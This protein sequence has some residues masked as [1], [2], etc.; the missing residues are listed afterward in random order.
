MTIPFYQQNAEDFFNATV[1][2]DMASLYAPFLERVG[3]QGKILDAGCGSGRDSKAFKALGYDVEA[4]DA[5][6]EMVALAS[7][8]AGIAA[9]QFTFAELDERERYDGIWCCASLLHVAVAELP[10]AMQRLAAALKH[11]GAWYVSF[12]YGSGEREK[13]GRHFT[14]LNEK[15][16]EALVSQLP[17]IEVVAMW[18]TQDKRPERSETWLNA[19]MRKR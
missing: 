9:R 1:G 8:Y 15:A 18:Q 7:E 16:L 12:K 10:D 17:D 13:D 11:R 19:L 14:D 6:P 2:V 3:P 4:F 5:T